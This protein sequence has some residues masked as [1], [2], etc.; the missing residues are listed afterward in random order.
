MR[1]DIRDG[2]ITIIGGLTVAAI[3][4][5]LLVGLEPGLVRIEPRPTPSPLPTGPTPPPPPP[6][7]T[8]LPEHLTEE[9]IPLRTGERYLAAVK[10][11]GFLV[12]TLASS[13]RVLEEAKK[14]GFENIIVTKGEPPFGAPPTAPADYYV[15]GTYARPDAALGR[16]HGGGAVRII[17]AWRLAPS[18]QG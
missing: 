11:D 4:G 3:V 1:A 8:G 2:L 12:K 10:L 5:R 18:G 17:D 14:Q 16:E 15:V 7:E 9:T 13:A 6:S